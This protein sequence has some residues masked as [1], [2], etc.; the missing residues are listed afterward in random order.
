MMDRRNSSSSRLCKRT[1]KLSIAFSLILFGIVSALV[2]K[3][4]SPSEDNAG[5]SLGGKDDDDDG[6][7]PWKESVSDGVNSCDRPDYVG[8]KESADSKDW[9]DKICCG[10][11]ADG[12]GFT[13]FQVFLSI[14]G[15][16]YM[17]LGIAIVCDEIFVPALEI[18][19]EKWELSN[20]VAGATLMAAGGSAPELFTSLIASFDRSDMGFSTIVGSAVFNVLFVIAM[21]ALCTPMKFC[22]LSLTWWPLARDCTFY[23]LTLIT[24][25]VFMADGKIE[26]WEAILQFLMY[27][28]YVIIMYYSS[29]LE[30]YVT[31]SLLQPAGTSSVIHCEPLKEARS[32]G[33]NKIHVSNNTTDVEECVVKDMN[34]DSTKDVTPRNNEDNQSDT[35]A[36][37]NEKKNG[38]ESSHEHK[39]FNRPSGF[40]AGILQILTAKGDMMDTAGVHCVSK[41]KGDVNKVFAELDANDDGN[42]DL[43]ELKNLLS[44]MGIPDHELSV[45]K[46][47]TYFEQ[48]FKD[49]SANYITKAEFVKWYLTSESRIQSEMKECFDKVDLN[50]NGT[51]ERSELKVLLQ[52]L[53]H[54]A[55]DEEVAEEEK[56]MNVSDAGM[57]LRDFEEWYKESIFYGQQVTVG[58]EAAESVES[59]WGTVKSGCGSLGDKELPLRAKISFVI[60]LPL[61]LVFCLVP[62]CRAP[63]RENWC[64]ASF[65]GSIVCIAG[66]SWVMVYFASGIG[67]FFEIPTFIMGV[68]VLAAGTS[69]PDLLSSVIVARQGH[70]DMAVSSSIGSNIFDVTVGIPLPWILFS[71]F[72][73]IND[74]TYGPTVDKDDLLVPTFILLLMVFLVVII[75]AAGGWKMTHS[76]GYIMFVLYFGYL[77]FA[78]LNEYCFHASLSL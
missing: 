54:K 19:S 34:G 10:A 42:L 46:V 21:C 68:T 45:E 27:V 2:Y 36:L 22:P 24:L 70:G 41:I 9:D 17:F 3:T 4:V 35:M 60:S 20:D 78:L 76:L 12:D 61:L 55:T 67:D 16:L 53:G 25:V 40:R 73:G 69:V 15:L 62:D 47:K 57:T 59:M 48:K 58:E 23:I 49:S 56:R 50:H 30:A 43:S 29:A 6:F 51:V 77:S 32:N 64:F 63:G 65:F 31:G 39:S 38:E 52:N 14:V 75:I 8:W 13:N 26:L 7:C 44:M 11:S 66:L 28:L 72:A 33:D 71:I 37:L 1:L 18:I 74:C 5:R